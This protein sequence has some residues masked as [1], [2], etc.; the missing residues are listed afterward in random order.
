M[1]EDSWEEG[2]TGMRKTRRIEGEGWRG[3]GE[4][5][6]VRGSVGW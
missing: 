3:G 4:E 5:E 1:S 6:Q 2:R